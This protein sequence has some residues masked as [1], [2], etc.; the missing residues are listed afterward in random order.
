MTPTTP[1]HAS[2]S[3]TKPVQF[4]GKGSEFFG[5]WIVN[6]LLSIITLGI[7][8]AWAKV[9]TNQYFYGHT[10]IDGHSFRYLATPMRILRGRLI[11]FT[12]FVAYSLISRSSPFL[13]V[14]LALLFLIAAPWLVVQ[15]LRFNLQMSSYRNVRFG[16]NGS[17]GGALVNLILLPILSVFTLYL[18]FPWALKRIDQFIYSGI[19]YGDRGTQVN[20]RTGVYYKAA[21]AAL[22]AA[23]VIG[24]LVFVVA[25]AAGQ[26]LAGQTANPDFTAGLVVLGLLYWLSITLLAAIYQSI[27]RNHLFQ[28]MTID[29]VAS[30]ES[31]LRVLPYAGLL[32]T[33]A[34]MVLC[35]V[36]FAYPFAKVRK[37]AYLA[38]VTAVV[39]ESGADQ[40]I[41]NL[42]SSSSAFGEE[43]AGFFD[44]DMSLT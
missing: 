7:Y 12:V 41:D 27:I 19:C 31:S 9:R 14:I 10:R 23:L 34:L 11:A 25:G 16:F 33:N 13:G 32:L 8:S 36:G 1:S 20:T 44:V 18:A 29:G 5:I 6:L 40:V 37:A 42:A 21:G 24:L 17:Y 30:F 2:H 4:S 38:S 43:A 15:S 39:I 35:T 28:S 3:P 22:L 26:S